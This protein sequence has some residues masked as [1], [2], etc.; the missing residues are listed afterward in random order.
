M[1]SPLEPS[2]IC[3][4][5]QKLLM[6]KW[7]SQKMW[8]FLPVD[9]RCNCTRQ[10]KYEVRINTMDPYKIMPTLPSDWSTQYERGNCNWIHAVIIWANEYLSNYMDTNQP[11][12]KKNPHTRHVFNVNCSCEYICAFTV[13]RFISTTVSF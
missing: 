11:L 12:L 5:S 7:A 9:S 4:L 13:T 1:M 10:Y 2:V 8:L 3:H 6:Y